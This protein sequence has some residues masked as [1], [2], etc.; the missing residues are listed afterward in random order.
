MQKQ[1]SRLLVAGFGILA[2]LASAFAASLA[3]AAAPEE[4]VVTLYGGT[5]ERGW[6]VNVIQPFEKQYNAEIRVVTGLSGDNLA[7]LRA[8]KDN[9]QIDVFMMDT[10]MAVVAAREGLLETLDAA[11]IP[12]LRNLYDFAMDSTQ[13]HVSI[14]TISVF[15]A[16]NTQYVKEKPT[17]WSDLWKP[18]Y[19]GKIL[20]P[21]MSQSSG[22]LFTAVLGHTFGKGWSDTEAAF[23]RLKSLRPNVLTFTTSHD[24]TAQLL[25]QGEGWMQPWLNDRIASQVKAGAPIGLAI[26]KEG[27]IFANGAMAIA[28]G[29]KRKALAEKYINFVLS[30][31]AQAANAA[32]IFLGPTNKNV[33]VSPEVAQFVPYG[34][35]MKRLFVVDWDEYRKLHDQWVDRW[36]REIK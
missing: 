23:A 17:S 13:Q 18:E 29:T 30:E 5:L 24:Q 12:N 11:R 2:L 16:Y 31:A 8:Q 26:P 27:S 22:V 3:L 21:A 34:D 35:M 9:P 28:K 19:K 7:K 14:Y 10:A 6:R 25:N 15:L 4:L 1:R 36:N 32:T 33:R 20:L